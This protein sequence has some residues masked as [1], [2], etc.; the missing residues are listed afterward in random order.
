MILSNS[1]HFFF[2]LIYFPFLFYLNI[3]SFQSNKISRFIFL[4]YDNLVIIKHS[5]CGFDILLLNDNHVLMIFP[6]LLPLPL[7]RPRPLCLWRHV[8]ACKGD[9]KR[10][11]GFSFYVRNQGLFRDEWECEWQEHLWFFSFSLN[12]YDEALISKNSS[13][14]R[15]VMVVGLGEGGGGFVIMVDEGIFLGKG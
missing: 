3:F 13:Y 15:V 1:C 8:V 2:I 7:L 10:Q 6:H 12:R 9:A 11:Q 14:S 4:N 5:P